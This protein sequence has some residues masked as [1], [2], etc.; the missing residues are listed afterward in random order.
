M[1]YRFR[2][3]EISPFTFEIEIDLKLLVKQFYKTVGISN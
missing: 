2:M 1:E 3:T